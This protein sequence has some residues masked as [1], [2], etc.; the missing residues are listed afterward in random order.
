ML[1]KRGFLISKGADS[2]P[3]SGREPPVGRGARPEVCIASGK[4]TRNSRLRQHMTGT[5][6]P[7]LINDR[8]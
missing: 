4:D 2:E 3:L 1:R 5:T 8:K 6:L 7:S